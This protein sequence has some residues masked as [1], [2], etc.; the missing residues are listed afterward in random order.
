M[1]WLVPVLYHLATFV[2][3]KEHVVSISASVIES[4]ILK[5]MEAY[6]GHAVGW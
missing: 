5:F 4:N 3:D 2:L 6:E 1:R